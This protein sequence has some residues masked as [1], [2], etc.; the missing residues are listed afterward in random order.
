M[1]LKEYAIQSLATKP[2]PAV[3]EEEEMNSYEEL[4]PVMREQ[5]DA[6]I[7]SIKNNVLWRMEPHVEAYIR[8]HASNL[9]LTCLFIE[10]EGKRKRGK[11]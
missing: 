8:E 5:V 9:V 7:A 1:K 6:Y 4:S 10:A 11:P 3:R 2:L